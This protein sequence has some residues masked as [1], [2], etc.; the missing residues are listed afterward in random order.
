MKTRRFCA[1]ANA[2][3]IRSADKQVIPSEETVMS[4]KQ[5]KLV[6]K[7]SKKIADARRVRFGASWAPRKVRFGASWGPAAL[8]K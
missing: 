2:R 3:C 4:R 6:R 8:R 1:N 7:P 5:K